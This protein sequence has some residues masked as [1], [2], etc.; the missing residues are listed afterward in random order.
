MISRRINIFH[1]FAVAVFALIAFSCTRDDIIFEQPGNSDHTLR[2]DRHEGSKYKNVF[3][4]YSA[5]YNNLSEE[6][7]SDVQDILDSPIPDSRRNAVLIFSHRTKTAYN[8]TDK[9]SPTLTH[10][11]KGTDGNVVCDTVLVFDP[12][13]SSV[14][15]ETVKEVLTYIRDTYPSERYGMMFSSHGTGWLPPLFKFGSS[16]KTSVNDPDASLYL[17]GQ[18]QDG[19]PAVRSIGY[20]A[21][22]NESA[23]EI[24]IKDFADAIPMYLDYMIFDACLMGSIEVAYEL[25]DKCRNLVVSPAE[26][27]AEGMDYNTLISYLMGNAEY[28]LTGFAENYYNFYNDP[29]RSSAYRSG[30]ITVVDCTKLDVLA[31]TC[32]GLFETYRQEISSLEKVTSY[33]QKYFTMSAHKC[34]YDLEDIILTCGITAE[35]QANLVKALDQCIPY[36]AST[37]YILGSIR[38]QNYSGLSMYIPLSVEK[39]LNAYYTTLKWN[40]ATGLIQE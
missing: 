31:E 13:T 9:T 29:S 25:K 11:Y 6:F 5:G 1:T 32:R 26:I 40:K 24:D 15:G 38:V 36:C 21:A 4:L 35:E 39:G 23:K 33:V 10:V 19:L 16:W 17:Y 2:P 8:Y 3:L 18:R 27:L 22:K 37:P 14:S 12:G 34:F 20:E 30:T 28:D 7:D